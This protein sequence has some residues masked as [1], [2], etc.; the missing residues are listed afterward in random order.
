MPLMFLALMLAAAPDPTLDSADAGGAAS[1]LA[2]AGDVPSLAATPD[3]HVTFAK[4]LVKQRLHPLYAGAPLEGAR[5]YDVVDRPELA[6][7]Y[8]SRLTGKWVAGVAGAAAIVTGILV[9]LLVGPDSSPC[10]VYDGA[11]SSCVK[12]RGPNLQA[13]GFVLS[14]VGVAAFIF[15]LAFPAD[16]VNEA[17]RFE[18]VEAHNQAVDERATGAPP[19]AA[20]PEDVTGR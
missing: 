13:P 15:A 6:V 8:Q 11:S 7:A 19:A 17:G 12:H 2:Q 1:K 5:F 10:I 4:P 18:L 20:K 14:G 16:P 3:E 9:G